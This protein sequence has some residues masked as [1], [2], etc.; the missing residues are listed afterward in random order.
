MGQFLYF[1]IQYVVALRSLIILNSSQPLLMT[2]SATTQT[3]D[4]KIQLLCHLVVQVILMTEVT[5]GQLYR[6]HW[7]SA[8]VDWEWNLLL[9]LMP[10]YKTTKSTLLLSRSTQPAV[11][12][13]PFSVTISYAGPPVPG[14]C[15][16]LFCCYEVSLLWQSF[17]TSIMPHFSASTFSYVLGTPR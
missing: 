17:A 14:G 3:T 1:Q 13:C 10:W 2:V 11:M 16:T 12:Q 5:A 7:H 9:L 6:P 8:T 4:L 15:Q